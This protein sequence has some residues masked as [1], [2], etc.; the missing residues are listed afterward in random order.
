[1]H[2]KNKMCYEGSTA[3]HIDTLLGLDRLAVNDVLDALF[4]VRTVGGVV[5]A[6]LRHVTDVLLA[7]LS[8]LLLAQLLHLL[9]ELSVIVL[10]LSQFECFDS[11]VLNQQPVLDL[12]KKRN[13][14]CQK[15]QTLKK[16]W[17][18]LNTPLSCGHRSS[19][20]RR[21]NRWVCEQEGQQQPS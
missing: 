5:L 18:E 21:N 3:Y 2:S 17:M 9:V 20:S 7:A 15:R 10:V 1:M 14:S 4:L 16:R 13:R 12:Q 19:S 6:D 11:L 8:T